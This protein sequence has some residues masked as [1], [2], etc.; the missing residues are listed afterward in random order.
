MRRLRARLNKDYRAAWLFL[1]YTFIF[2]IGVLG[3]ADV[4]L[5]FYFVSIGYDQ[6]S[7]GWLQGMSRIGGL[8]TSVPVGLIAVRYG[9]QR[10]MILSTIGIAIVY[11]MYVAFP[12]LG[13]LLA[14]RFLLGV[15]YGAQQI[16]MIPY[17][18]ALVRPDQ[19][20]RFFAYQNVMAMAGMA[21]GG[22]IGGFIPLWVVGLAM[23]I[24]PVLAAGG[25]QSPFAYG[26]TLLLC[27]ALTLASIL[28]FLWL[29]GRTPPGAGPH[30]RA[31]G[32]QRIR[33]QWRLLIFLTLPMIPFGF[34][35]G[36]TFPF[37]NLFFRDVFGQPDAAV[38]I[39]LSIGWI[40]MALVPLANPWWERRF[41]R[42]WSIFLVMTIASA[43]FVVLGAAG[44]LVVG[45][46]AYFVAVS[47]RNVMQ[48]MYQPLL[49][50]SLPPDQ[51]S[52]AS[53]MSGVLWN[54]GWF[55]ATAISGTWQ[56]TLGYGFIMHVVAVG[57]LV[58]GASVVLIFRHRS[59]SRPQPRPQ[60]V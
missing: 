36:L 56:T 25:A 55:T 30:K 57:V 10:T 51:H 41:G 47:F 1:V 24:V 29:K 13:M 32:E 42:P 43:A 20:T 38:G 44:A 8:L 28:P 48:P 2:H 53:S 59:S 35:G 14:A 21:L 22:M 15:F 5:N 34:T 46:A 11:V 7:I 27:A 31:P 16:A 23:P 58:C 3:I 52:M 6:A 37:Y 54:L 49:M 50:N 45:V 26:S 17:M 12:S 18:I 60:T 40:G 19:Q 33:F 4:V 9:A 39:I